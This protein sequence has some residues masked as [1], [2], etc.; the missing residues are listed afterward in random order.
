MSNTV[1]KKVDSISI[2]TAGTNLNNIQ[3]SGFYR[4]GSVSSDYTNCP[5]CSYGQMLVIY[6]G[7]DTIAQLLFDYS[8]SSYFYLRVGNVVGNSN[9]S[10]SVW[11]QFKSA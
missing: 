9:G 10:W 4:L 3:K 5:G 1:S 8:S 11:K 7:G 2:I 6:G